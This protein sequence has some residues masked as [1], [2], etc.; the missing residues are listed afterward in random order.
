MSKTT[1]STAAGSGIGML[2]DSPNSRGLTFISRVVPKK[3]MATIP[4][5]TIVTAPI[6]TTGRFGTCLMRKAAAPPSVR[7]TAAPT[8][9]PA[10]RPTSAPKA[11][12]PM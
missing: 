3:P 1:A 9:A 7:P 10:H 6:A 4:R 8:T 5:K 11:A 12:A 2:G